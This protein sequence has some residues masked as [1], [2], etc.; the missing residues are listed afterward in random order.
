MR[1]P[2][3]AAPF[4]KLSKP[5]GVKRGSISSKWTVDLHMAFQ[6]LRLSFVSWTDPGG[7]RDDGQ[8]I[9]E[10]TLAAQGQQFTRVSGRRA[11]AAT[12]NP[13]VTQTSFQAQ[14]A[15]TWEGAP[16]SNFSIK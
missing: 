7:R 16:H 12:S 6:S 8:L 4:I 10:L 2:T 5:V 3:W 13:S 11:T 9:R 1:R 14:R 15:R